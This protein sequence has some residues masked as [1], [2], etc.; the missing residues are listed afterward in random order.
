M[1]WQGCLDAAARLRGD[2]LDLRRMTWRAHIFPQVLGIPGCTGLGSVVV[3][4]IGHALADGSRADRTGRCA[5]GPSRA[6]AGARCGAGA[7]SCR[8]AEWPPPWRIA[9]WCATPRRGWCR[10]PRQACP[11]L[12]INQRPARYPGGADAGAAPRS[13]CESHRDDRSAG[14]DLRGARRAISPSV[15]R[16]PSAL[17]A[18]VTM[19]GQQDPGAHNNFRNVGIRL[20]P[21]VDRAERARADRHR[22]GGAAPPRPAP[23]DAD[24]GRRV[25]RHTRGAVAVGSA[26]VRSGGPLRDGHRQHRGVQREP[27]TGRPVLRRMRRSCS[28]QGSRR[29]RR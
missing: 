20:H 3:V 14:R 9:R 13:A 24:V 2:Q 28:P 5:A 11:V 15:A 4:Q 29:C 8:R 7:D 6:G 27:R 26:A 1:D 18:E 16:T 17:G 19:A 21:E 22:A 25:C 12:S 23:G 10:R